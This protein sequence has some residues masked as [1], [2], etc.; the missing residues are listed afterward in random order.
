MSLL[1]KQLFSRFGAPE[2]AMLLLVA[3][4]ALPSFYIFSTISCGKRTE[5]QFEEEGVG[6]ESEEPGV[7]E[8]QGSE[9]EG[10]PSGVSGEGGPPA[11]KDGQPIEMSA[12]H[13]Q[14]N[15][16]LQFQGEPTEEFLRNLKGVLLAANTFVWSAQKR[17]AA[18]TASW[19]DLA[20]RVTSL[21]TEGFDV[22]PGSDE[23]KHL[24]RIESQR[25]VKPPLI[26]FIENTEPKKK[27]KKK[28]RKNK[29]ENGI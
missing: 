3:V 18:Q 23:A 25:H 22:I 21:Q 7:P 6:D 17:A 9:G 11:S 2:Y 10:P 1:N 13:P 12:N 24:R 15:F 26:L 14:I 29:R 19:K 16:V 27:K 8:S 5:S 28:K 4:A 20:R